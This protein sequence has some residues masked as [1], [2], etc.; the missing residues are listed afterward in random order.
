[1]PPMQRRQDTP[2]PV[3]EVGSCSDVRHD[4]FE[5]YADVFSTWPFAVVRVHRFLGRVLVL[6]HVS[7]TNGKNELV[8]R[9][10]AIDGRPFREVDSVATYERRGPG[11]ATFR[12]KVLA[13]PRTPSSC[14][15]WTHIDDPSRPKGTR[16]VKELYRYLELSPDGVREI[17][18]ETYNS[19]RQNPIR[20]KS[21][22][23][24]RLLT[25]CQRPLR[26]DA[27]KVFWEILEE[28]AASYDH[29]RF[30]SIGILGR[31][32]SLL[33]P[34]IERD[35]R[36]GR[37]TSVETD[38]LGIHIRAGNWER[39]PD[40]P[41]LRTGCDSTSGDDGPDGRKD[42]AQ[43]TEAIITEEQDAGHDGH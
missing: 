35:P 32:L 18:I 28:L 3:G 5:T 13:L 20:E 22:L 43:S 23:A 39:V 27:E 4:T 34:V 30:R 16:D 38:A 26:R 12:I 33:G 31:A 36:S 24:G 42:A 40:L 15:F 2:V 21:T 8:R 41:S 14:K 11:D 1:M 17:D 6:G 37:A 9:T 29:S 7:A 19:I 25:E 10:C